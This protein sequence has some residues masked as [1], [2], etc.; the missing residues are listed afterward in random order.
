M[1][2]AKEWLQVV[3]PSSIN[4]EVRCLR[5]SLDLTLSS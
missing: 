3:V 4:R 1:L 5:N 2:G